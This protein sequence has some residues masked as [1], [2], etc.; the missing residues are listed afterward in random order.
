[1]IALLLILLYLYV[2]LRLISLLGPVDVTAFLNAD[3][4]APRR[5]HTTTPMLVKVKFWSDCQSPCGR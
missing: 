1:M 5:V 3:F 2:L 4:P